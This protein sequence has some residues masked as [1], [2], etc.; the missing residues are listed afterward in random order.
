MAKRRVLIVDQ[1]AG[2]SPYELSQQPMPFDD[3]I[4]QVERDEQAHPPFRPARVLEVD[5]ATF[6]PEWCT[7][8]FAADE[9][10]RAF[11]LCSNW[12]SSG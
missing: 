7:T 4:A 6:Q 12:D 5:E 2:I 11:V 3:L 9:A 1:F 10:G 8:V